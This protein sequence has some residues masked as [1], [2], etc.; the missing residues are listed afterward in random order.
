MNKK[1]LCGWCN[2]YY[3]K[4]NGHKCNVANKELKWDKKGNLTI[5][6]LKQKIK[7]K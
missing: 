3:Y 7:R 1:I 6:E 2:K 5:E 4:E